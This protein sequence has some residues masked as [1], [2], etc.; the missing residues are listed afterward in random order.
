MHERP[1]AF[2]AGLRRTPQKDRSPRPA[3]QARRTTEPIARAIGR[4]RAAIIE[5]EAHHSASAQRLCDG[6]GRSCPIARAIGSVER[7]RSLLSDRLRDRL[8]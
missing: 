4:V 7:R 3:P 8:G 1:V 2:G 5:P 6:A